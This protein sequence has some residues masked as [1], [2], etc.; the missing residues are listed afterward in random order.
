MFRKQDWLVS[1]GRSEILNF[2]L[3]FFNATAMLWQLAQVVAFHLPRRAAMMKMDDISFLRAR[4]AR[5]VTAE[6]RGSNMHIDDQLISY[7]KCLDGRFDVTYDGE[8][9]L[10]AREPPTS[11]F[12][13]NAL[14]ILIERHMRELGAG[15]RTKYYRRSESA[16]R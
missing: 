14:R 1:Q 6:T 5:S 12:R 15:Q 10:V 3:G 4:A 7:I 2:L 16:H 11:D 13:M 9:I 8:P